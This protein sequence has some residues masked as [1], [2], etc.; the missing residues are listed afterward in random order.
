M[1]RPLKRSSLLNAALAEDDSSARA[2]TTA[3]SWVSEETMVAQCGVGG[4][5]RKGGTE[6]TTGMAYIRDKLTLVCK[7]HCG[8]KQPSS[9]VENDHDWH[10]IAICERHEAAEA[11]AE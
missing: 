7:L 9:P 5:Y 1:P 8:L 10:D 11:C 4:G 6:S 3:E 2:A